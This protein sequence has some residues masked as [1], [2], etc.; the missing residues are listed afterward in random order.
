MDRAKAL[1]K[2]TIRKPMK[3]AQTKMM[4]T[5]N[6]SRGT[7]WVANILFIY[8]FLIFRKEIEQQSERRTSKSETVGAGQLGREK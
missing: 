5:L 6:G 4:W 1:R 8:Y 3:W 7:I 2:L